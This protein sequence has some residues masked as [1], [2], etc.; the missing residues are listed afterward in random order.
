MALGL[1]SILTHAFGARRGINDTDIPDIAAPPIAV[2]WIRF[3]GSSVFGFHEPSRFF[4]LPATR[5]ESTATGFGMGSVSVACRKGH[6][7]SVWDS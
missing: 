6:W 7:E 3:G 2:S 5:S 1:P 4:D